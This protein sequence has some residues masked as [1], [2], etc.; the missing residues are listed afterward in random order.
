[1]CHDTRFFVKNV[2]K[3]A[4]NTTWLHYDFD[5]NLLDQ[6]FELNKGYI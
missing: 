3:I 6:A 2:H 4:A 1:M 5:Q